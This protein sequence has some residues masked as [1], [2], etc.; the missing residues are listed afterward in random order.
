MPFA[1]DSADARLRSIHAMFHPASIAVV[2]ATERLGY[3]GRF[4]KNLIDTGSA[5][6]LYPVN[7]ARKTVFGLP[8]HPSMAEVPEPVDLAAII[9]PA[10]QV[11]E[12]FRACV[13]QGAKAAL[14]ISA[15]FAEA[16]EEGEARQAAIRAL[17]RESGVRICGPNCLGL[18]NVAAGSWTTPSTRIA[19]ELR[20]LSGRIGLVSQ[21][22]A[23]CYRPLMAM[24]KDRGIG[25]RYMVSTG[26]EA[27][28][29][30][31]DFV[32]YMLRDPEVGAVA[33]V[34]EGFKDGRRF[35]EVAR[36]AAALSKPIVL[37]K[38]GRTEA[39]SRAAG[40][41]TAAMT[42]SDVVQ[43]ALFR[44]T[45]V[46]RVDDYD[47]L[48][49]TADMLVKAKP[50]RGRRAGVLSESGGMTSF[51]A[52]RA[53]AEGFSVPPLSDETT[54]RLRLIMGERG[55]AAN[56]ADL[57]GF[58]T[59]PDF[60]AVLAHYL[61][62]DGLD[63]LIMS[64]V[65]GKVQATTVIEATATA[66]KPI[67]FVWAGSIADG[68][69][70]PL[71]R[72]SAVPLFLLPGKAA[73]A[74]RRA[75]EH[76]RMRAA[77]QGEGDPD[78]LPP[79]PAGALEALRKE[80]DQGEGAVIGEHAGKRVLRAFG[81]RTTREALCADA[82][83]AVRAAAAIGYPV[84]LKIASPDL[85]HKTEAGGVRLGIADEAALLAARE[86]LL[87]AARAHAP[88]ARIEGVLIQEMV[89][90]G[91]EVILGVSRDPQFGPVVMLGQGGVMA[92][93]L[94]AAAWRVCPLNAREALEMIDEVG[95]LRRLLAG[96]RGAPPADVAALVDAV[97]RVSR[98]AVWAEDDLA[99]LDI[100]PLAVLPEGRGAVALDALLVRRGLDGRDRGTV[101]H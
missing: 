18:T 37:L 65:G 36:R 92:E 44:Q 94:G 19:P 84:A 35:V 86:E 10:A 8:C 56:P 74:A 68:E 64:S 62:E 49:E 30:S 95:G 90:G 38:I 70:L 12:V 40:S 91:I 6:R 101:G 32:D 20:A 43:D 96:F 26:N 21:S 85:A 67:L 89:A 55:S 45:A 34:V 72:A 69:G 27:D 23:T 97:V 14:I 51:M 83:G 41:H 25:L 63:L 48:L 9:V 82:A 78:A 46:V 5:A 99:G 47:E 11:P 50:P 13:E 54:R 17:A 58:G 53:A 24:A 7:R 15:G 4:L 76:H 16:G 81:I 77:L 1:L 59:G 66:D 93:A 39:G 31:S 29:E 3:G 88:E 100:N 98:L 28:L 75:V 52:D 71:L 80:L 87:A 57:T 42:G 2:G 33:A 22:G 79:P 60:P 61:A 73:L